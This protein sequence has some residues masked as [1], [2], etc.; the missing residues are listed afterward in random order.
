MS[1][2]QPK[3]K[4]GVTTTQENVVELRPFQVSNVECSS[5][6]DPT[7]VLEVSY[8]INDPNQRIRAG[9]IVYEAPGEIYGFVTIHV[10]KL[11][12][13]QYVHGVR[14]KVQMLD[15]W[16]GKITRGLTDRIGKRV[17]ADLSDIRVRVEVWNNANFEPGV[18]ANDGMGRTSVA[19]EWLSMASTEVR[20]LAIV[21]AVWDTHWV[22]PFGDPDEPA[23][24]KAGMDI[25][26]KNVLDGTPARLIV[27]RIGDICEPSTDFDYADELSAEQEGL[28]AV[29]KGDKILL[30]N[31]AKPFVKFLNYDEHWVHAGNNFY[32]FYVAFGDGGTAMPASE[33]DYQNNEKACLHM[34]FTVFIHLAVPEMEGLRINMASLHNFFRGST[35]Y[36]RSYLMSGPPK[37]VRD[38]LA[39]FDHRYV[40]I[41]EGHAAC[42]CTHPEHPE[43][44]VGKGK[45]KRKVKLDPYH[46]GFV[47]DL[48]VCPVELE[49]TKAAKAA[50][51]EDMAHYKTKFGGCGN[52]SHVCH[53]NL[54]GRRGKSAYYLG[55][56]RSGE[57]LTKL[58]VY[59][60]NP[61]TGGYIK[62]S[63]R[64]PR[65]MFWNGGCR[66]ILTTNQGER[67]VQQEAGTRYYHG[68]HY[69]TAD[70][71]FCRAFFMRWIQGT[72]KDPAPNE[73]DLTRFE[74][75]YR[76]LAKL[77]TRGNDHPRLMN[78]SG[79]L[80]PR[81]APSGKE[82][83]TK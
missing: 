1:S 42:F 2:P 13:D 30:A 73:Y 50:I 23:K 77:G 71:E 54:L 62:A 40:V 9:R 56:N 33:R 43:G 70:N 19:G 81:E 17:T 4:A 11:K 39:H 83:A 29:V 47:P 44:T 34:R 18:P 76:D 69:S 49:D 48:N 36:Y 55:I 28:Q 3:A 65:L 20:I 7:Y 67:L 5:P 57:D 58:A 27:K 80:N 82:D 32:A 64:V 51:Q 45:L 24:G 21:K 8:D 53:K 72:K 79:V 26:V 10:Q 78:S 41:M 14:N 75:V 35:K 31:G 25:T 59:A 46:G 61:T 15:C 60:T 6:W 16:D 38:W 22:I 12:P 68:W 37:D 63:G 74:S 66:G 52:R